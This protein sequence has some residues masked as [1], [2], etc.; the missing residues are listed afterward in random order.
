MS[1]ARF[2]RRT[3]CQCWSMDLPTFGI[4]EEFLL[5]DE[6]TGELREDAEHVLDRAREL[7]EDGL[8]HELRAA[9]LEIGTAVSGSWCS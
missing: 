2:H 4:E 1:R 8:D 3:G 7:F 9:M 6:R 5:T